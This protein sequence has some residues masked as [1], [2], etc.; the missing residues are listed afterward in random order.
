VEV[1]GG[2]GG[3]KKGGVPLSSSSSSGV[4]GEPDVFSL[5]FRGVNKESVFRLILTPTS[6]SS[7]TIWAESARS[8]NQWQLDVVDVNTHGPLDS[9]NGSLPPAVVYRYLRQ[10]LEALQASQSSQAQAE[11][12]GAGGGG[13]G[14][15][16]GGE[17]V[18]IDA[19]LTLEGL[20][21]T[22]SF[23]VVG[24]S[25][26]YEFKLVQKQVET[27]DVVESKIR[28]TEEELERL[29]REVAE[30]KAR[31]SSLEARPV[32]FGVIS[33]SMNKPGT[34]SSHLIAG[35]K[36]VPWTTSV[37][38][39]EFFDLSADAITITIKKSGLY[40][41]HVISNSQDSLVYT[42]IDKP[43]G[44]KSVSPLRAKL[45]K[46]GINGK[47]CEY[48]DDLKFLPSNTTIK[49]KGDSQVGCLDSLLCSIRLL[50]EGGEDSFLPR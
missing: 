43:R 10:A 18:A 21:L 42:C 2:G 17:D 26:V 9:S 30:L 22:L 50:C 37:M 20:L 25:F 13:G 28:D 41:I 33:L 29:R 6:P 24:L 3:G 35:Q 48:S 5:V 14:D 44:P 19:A 27:K 16:A 1:S 40:N 4:S 15:S 11:G 47:I 34:Q 46:S 12:A 39:R 7:T 49:I 38:M 32:T 31:V 8:K 45:S 36:E 23:N